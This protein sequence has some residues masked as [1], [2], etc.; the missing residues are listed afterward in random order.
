[1]VSALGKYVAEQ[2]F[3]LHR[4]KA[5]RMLDEALAE[6]LPELRAIQ[7]FQVLLQEGW[8]GS[9]A[10]A[11]NDPRGT[12]SGKYEYTA[13]RGWQMTAKEAQTAV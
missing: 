10:V 3:E 11:G 5:S 9:T 6:Q 4:L 12:V 7:G 1:M 13:G 2:R 8:E